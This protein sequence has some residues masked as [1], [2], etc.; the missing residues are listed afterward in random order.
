LLFTKKLNRSNMKPTMD[1][2]KNITQILLADE[3]SY[4]EIRDACGSLLYLF[5]LVT[6]FDK[7]NRVNQQ[8]MQSKAGRAVSPE[9]AAFCIRDIMRTRVFMRG[10]KEAVSTKLQANPDKAVTVLYAGTGPFATLLIPLATMF[11]PTQLNMLLLD[12]NPASITYLNNIISYFNLHAYVLQVVE[13]DAV[14]YQMPAQWQPDI[15]LSETMMPSLKSEPQLS[16]VA[17]LAGQRPQAILIPEEIEVSAALYNSKID[18]EIKYIPLETLLVLTKDS[19]L[20]MA[21]EQQTADVVFPEMRLEIQQPQ[22]PSYSR[23]ALLT[24]IRV[25]N[26]HT[27]NF[28]ESSLTIP[29]FVYDLNDI[30]TWPAVF[31]ISYRIFPFPGFIIYKDDLTVYEVK[32]KE[33]PFIN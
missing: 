26:K 30:K 27:L 33:N 9:A 15:I 28:K 23:L 17:N 6:E 21:A 8:H 19:A 29:E 3:S 2:L 16:I 22:Q 11:S 10:L 5:Y 13:T 25:F 31:N 7:E 12:I 1:D 4:L 32:K 24:N 14:T 18:D 20:K